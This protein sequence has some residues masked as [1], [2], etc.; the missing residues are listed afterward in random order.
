MALTIR[1]EICRVRA[2]A[3]KAG[4]GDPVPLLE[5]R[6][7]KRGRRFIVAFA[8]FFNRHFVAL[9]RMVPER[10]QNGF[11]TAMTTM[12]IMSIVGASFKNR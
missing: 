9:D 8:E 6:V 11:T 2:G 4:S 12:R 1:G 7:D 5:T 10:R 3:A